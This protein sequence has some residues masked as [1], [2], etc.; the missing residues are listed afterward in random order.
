MCDELQMSNKNILVEDV[1]TGWNSTYD[2]IEAAWEKREVLKVMESDYLNT[3]KAKI[4]IEDEAWELL[5]MF[6]DELLVFCEATQVFSKSKSITSPNVSWLYGLLVEWLDSLIFELHHPLQDFTGTK[7]S[8]DQAKGRAY[9]SMKEKLLKYEM[10]VR[11]KRMFPIAT[12]LDPRFKLEQIPH[13]EK[14]FVMENLLNM[15]ESVRIIEGSSSMSIDDLL[16]SRTHKHSKVMMQFMKRQSSRS[17]IVDEQ[18]VK[19][20]LDDY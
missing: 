18:S 11:R 2:M 12:M 9:T 16:A 5:K 1:R 20:E 3:N 8:N 15:L 13:G 17:T 10:Q 14:K 7:M 4:L 19:V 6:A